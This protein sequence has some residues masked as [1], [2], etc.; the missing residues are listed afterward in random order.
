MLF[1]K[2]VDTKIP[3]NYFA[4]AA[5]FHIPSHVLRCQMLYRE[6]GSYKPPPFGSLLHLSRYRAENILITLVS[7]TFCIERLKRVAY[8]VFVTIRDI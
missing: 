3:N 1:G 6:C 8:Y 7:F 4:H 5:S 2:Q